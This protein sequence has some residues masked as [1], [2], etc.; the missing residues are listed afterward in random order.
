MA[1]M[2]QA[3]GQYRSLPG[4]PTLPFCSGVVADPGFE[5]VHAR[6][7][8]PLPWRA[9][10]T[11]IER[12][13][14]SLG[15]PRAALCAV[16]LRVG[17][18]YTSE[19][20]FSPTGFNGHYGALLK[21][22]G[23]VGATARTNIAVDLVPLPEQ[24]IFAFSYTVPTPDAP[25]TFIV[26]GA[27]EGAAVRSGEVSPEALRAKTADIMATLSN[28]LASLG[29]GWEQSTAVGLYTVH[30]LFPCLR[31]EVLAKAGA[32]A[33][34]GIEWYEGRPPVV[35]SEVEI[36]VRGVRQELR[37]DLG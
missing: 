16:E 28:R 17:K 18:P 4:T 2:G 22:W 20:F 24:V 3:E 32:A 26:S 11:A 10:F 25:P 29:V 30:D 23:L 9:G 15:R 7:R 5:I 33:L 1:L 34:N 37:L 19:E 31:A 8:R 35:G 27:P 36:D 13:L 14:A 12:H 6:L 21:E